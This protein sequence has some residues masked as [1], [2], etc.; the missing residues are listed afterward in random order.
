[1]LSQWPVHHDCLTVTTTTVEYTVV[2]YIIQ[3]N[4]VLV[5]NGGVNEHFLWACG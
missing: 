5:N 4:S 1:M 3:L 2:R